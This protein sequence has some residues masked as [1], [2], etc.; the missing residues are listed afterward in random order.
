MPSFN[1][2][3]RG[4]AAAN[5]D[6][7]FELVEESTGTKLERK[8]FRD[9]SLTIRD[10]NPGFYQLKVK[11]PNLINPIDQRR[12]RLYP[13]KQP[14]VVHVPIPED[15]F[16]D[17]P[18]RDIPDADLTPVQQAATEAAEKVAPLSPKAPG[19]V[20]KSNDWNV[21][22]DAVSDL[23]KAVLELTNLISPR[24]HDHPEI[25]E[26]IGE[27]QGNLMRFSEAYGKS[28]LELQREIE[29]ANL[30][31]NVEETLDAADATN[32]IRES[33]LARVKDM[34]DIAQANTIHFTQKLASTGSFLLTK[35]NEMA[36]AKGDHA[37]TF[38]N[39]KSVQKAMQLANLY[40]ETGPVVSADQEINTYRKSST[41][42]GGLKFN[43][44]VGKATSTGGK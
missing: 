6:A 8:P 15:L 23:S 44:A 22:V 14:T 30:K 31:R 43:S 5:R 26:K 13:Q 16:K 11:H 4:F 20:I 42:T 36:V 7:V 35:I 34:E 32:A 25:A 9:G 29:I 17:S 40:A 39:N 41:A 18:I 27:V 19:E 33:V 24:G 10:L 2:K 21:L 1:F 37:D 3:M 12:I 28:L 38:I